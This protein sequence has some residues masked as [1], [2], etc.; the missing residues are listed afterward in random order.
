MKPLNLEKYFC[1]NKMFG[2][3]KGISEKKIKNYLGLLK[4]YFKRNTNVVKY[5]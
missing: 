4:S 1:P 2:K 5:I 3:T